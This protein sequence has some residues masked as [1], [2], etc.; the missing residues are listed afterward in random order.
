MNLPAFIKRQ[1]TRRGLWVARKTSVLHDRWQEEL[2]FDWTFVIAR[3]LTPSAL[4]ELDVLPIETKGYAA[5]II[6]ITCPVH[7]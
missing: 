4:I 1:F 3:L 6:S 7:R 2:Y 5:K